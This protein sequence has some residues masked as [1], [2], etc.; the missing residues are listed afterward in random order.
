MSF[1]I[2]SLVV[3]RLLDCLF[4]SVCCLTSDSHRFAL[5]PL[6]G[7]AF[8]GK[9]F[10]FA[11]YFQVYSNFSALT[12]CWKETRQRRA[13]KTKGLPSPVKTSRCVF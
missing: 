13:I 12:G 3:D 8:S 10:A 2:L 6:E 9:C 1:Q 4:H 11:K 5:S 7:V